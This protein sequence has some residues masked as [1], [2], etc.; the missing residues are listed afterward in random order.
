MKF[1]RAE[2]APKTSGDAFDKNYAYNVR[3]NYAKE[4]KRTDYTPY[5]C[6]KIIKTPVPMVSLLSP[7]LCHCSSR[8]IAVNKSQYGAMDFERI[9]AST[10]LPV[11][12]PAFRAL[13]SHRQQFMQL[14]DLVMTS[15]ICSDT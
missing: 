11:Y 2:F 14:I 5:S 1:W 9:A 8:G 12:Q 4:G 13:K 3:Y 6:L 15:G 7:W 10:V